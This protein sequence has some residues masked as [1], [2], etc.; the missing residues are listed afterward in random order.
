MI[1]P[2]SKNAR[3]SAKWQR[4]SFLSMVSSEAEYRLRN[5]KGGIGADLA[6]IMRSQF[7]IEQEQGGKKLDGLSSKSTGGGGFRA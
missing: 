3:V 7:W 6:P 4:N 5:E 2:I 1:F